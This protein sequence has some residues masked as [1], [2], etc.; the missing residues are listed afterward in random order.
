MS[1]RCTLTRGICPLFQFC[2]EYAL[3]VT[4]QAVYKEHKYLLK[5]RWWVCY[6]KLKHCW[7]LYFKFPPAIGSSRFS[8]CNCSHCVA[9]QVG[10]VD[11]SQWALGIS[12]GCFGLFS[13]VFL[14]KMRFGMICWQPENDGWKHDALVLAAAS[15]TA[16]KWA[17]F[18]GPGSLNPA[19]WMSKSKAELEIIT[20]Q[21][22]L[23]PSFYSWQI[24]SGLIEN[25]CSRNCH[26][27]DICT[28][29]RGSACN[30]CN[31][32]CGE[33]RVKQ[34]QP[35][36]EM[37][38]FKRVSILKVHIVSLQLKTVN[39]TLGMSLVWS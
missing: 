31:A 32:C 34:A 6:Q 18:Y 27:T 30:L 14:Q 10:V 11:L 2:T 33:E 15:Q 13:A 36:Q 7:K 12:L 28:E 21:C 29:D 16:T 25:T 9:S 1:G 20:R 17:S 38:A 24:S 23:Q 3:H 37:T 19:L 26:K 5:G 4:F 39:K 8:S 22:A 35:T